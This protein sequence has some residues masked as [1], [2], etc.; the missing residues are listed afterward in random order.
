MSANDSIPQSVRRFVAE[1]IGS[2]ETLEALL[3]VFAEPT[4]R[5]SAAELGREART[6]DWS[7]ERQLQTLHRGGVLLR[8]GPGGPY[9][10]NPAF[11]MI[12]A[13]VERTLRRSRV[14][15]IALIYATP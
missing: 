4:R 15:L 6:N 2:V 1:H 7:A 10:A 5:W 9:Q 13:E 14:A 12:V 8:I 3:L 11:A